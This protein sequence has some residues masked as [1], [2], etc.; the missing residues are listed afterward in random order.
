MKFYKQILPFRL[1]GI[2]WIKKVDGKKQ[3][4]WNY[5]RSRGLK[6]AKNIVCDIEKEV[7]VLL[8]NKKKI[9]ILE[10][11]CGYGKLLLELKKI[12]G[13]R[14]ST[15]GINKE[16]T[17]NLTLIKK[18]AV[19]EKIFSKEE[20]TKNLPRLY[21]LDVDKKFP[22]KDNSF[23]L[24]FSVRTIQYISNKAKFLENLNRI[25]NPSGIVITDIQDGSKDKPLEFRHRWEILAKNKKIS[26]Y[27]LLSKE[28]SVHLSKERGNPQDKYLKMKKDPKFRLNLKFISSFNLHNI[29]PDWWGTKS[30]FVLGK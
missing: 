30:V 11:G 19:A 12:F 13:D 16:K 9:K 4:V 7:K 14:V 25:V 20:V 2:Y 22:F 21:L 6:E 10:V 18:F 3:R 17:W 24:V 27:Q 15:F 1:M 26:I 23:D 8:K 29:N 28:K 5:G